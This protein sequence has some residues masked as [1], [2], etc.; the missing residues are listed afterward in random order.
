MTAMVLGGV[1]SD[2]TQAEVVIVTLPTSGERILPCFHAIILCRFSGLPLL[3]IVR[4]GRS[5]FLGV[6]RL[7]LPSLRECLREDG[8][9]C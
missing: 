4:L 1:F 2:G 7:V 3:S 8:A 9:S 5:C 6:G